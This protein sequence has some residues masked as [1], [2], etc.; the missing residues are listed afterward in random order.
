MANEL[1]MT[2][3]TNAARVQEIRNETNICLDATAELRDAM[4]EDE[5]FAVGGIYQWRPADRSQLASEKRPIQTYNLT[6]SIIDFVAGYQSERETDPRAFPRGAEDAQLG[7][8][9]TALM[10]YAFDRSGSLGKKTLAD[11]FRGGI[12][13]GQ[14][15]YEIGHSYEYTDDML[16]GDIN[17][18]VLP[19]NS[20]LRDLGARRYDLADA[21]WMTKLMWVTTSRKQELWPKSLHLSH[22]QDWL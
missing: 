13:V 18:D 17:F 16:N 15:F 14:R 6:K 1:E 20:V 11:W 22:A 4:V 10:K 8:I 3:D 2:A 21:K 9:V 7:I 12:T 5:Q 19:T